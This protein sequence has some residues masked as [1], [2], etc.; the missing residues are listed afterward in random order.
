MKA[1]ELTLSESYDVLR[2]AK[3]IAIVGV[4]LNERRVSNRITKV[5]VD[6]G[7]DLYLVN[8]KYEGQK[9]ENYVIY[10]SLERLK[11]EIGYLDIV[12]VFRNPIYMVEEAKKAIDYGD[13]GVFWM[14]PGTDSGNAIDLMLR[15][16]HSIVKEKCIGVLA[17]DLRLKNM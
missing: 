11:D 12:C 4:S 13:F 6:L 8:P 17:T 1:K 15:N 16:N 2:N 14:Q 9:F 7:Y 10:S 5:M 3:K